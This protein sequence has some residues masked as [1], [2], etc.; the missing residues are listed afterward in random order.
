MQDDILHIFSKKKFFL[1]LTDCICE[2]RVVHFVVADGNPEPVLANENLAESLRNECVYSFETKSHN[3]WTELV[4]WWTNSCHCRY[5]SIAWGFQCIYSDGLTT[6]PGSDHIRGSHGMETAQRMRRRDC[7]M[8][9]SE[10][11]RFDGNPAYHDS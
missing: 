7:R 9:G 5:H 4:Q 10:N 3:R 2:V 11:I 8:Y 6:V 1:P